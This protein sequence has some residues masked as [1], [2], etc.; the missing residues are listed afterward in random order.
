MAAR[1]IFIP[2]KTLSYLSIV[3][4]GLILGL[5][6]FGQGL[7]VG[8]GADPHQL[9]GCHKAAVAS[10][11]DNSACLASIQAAGQEEGIDE[12]VER[13]ARCLAQG[14]AGEAVP[15]ALTAWLRENHPIYT[16]K[17]PIEADQLRGYLMYLLASGPPNEELFGYVKN[18]LLFAGHAFNVA[19]AAHT[20]RRFPDKGKELMPLLLPFLQGA[21]QEEWVDIT[22]YELNYPLGHPT[23]ARYE[24]IK[25][26][27]HFGPEAYPA[28][29]CLR[30]TLAEEGQRHEALRDAVLIA[31]CQQA[32]DGILSATPLCCRKEAPDEGPSAV[33]NAQFIPVKSRAKINAAGVEWVDQDG[34]PVKYSD[35]TGKPFVLTFF[36]TRCTNMLKCA[37]TVDRLGKLQQL[38]VSGGI[39]KKVGIYAMTYDPDFDRPSILRSYG[40]AYGLSFADKV[41][42]LA[43]QGNSEKGLSEQ[44]GL[45]VG[46]G[47]G[48]V[49]QHGI[50]L[51]VMDKKGRIAFV[52]DN[53]LWSAAAVYGHLRQLMKE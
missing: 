17:S 9:M 27:P 46:Y 28:V 15:L 36:Y 48:S 51:L 19:A 53:E 3:L 16:G 22:T 47:H 7:T 45:R 38:A 34:R 13:A 37:A 32:I 29:K 26:L 49:N 30:A 5:P 50:Q 12:L 1:P 20:A 40:E 41:K 14:S 4:L 23:K 24:V 35:L 25:T 42:F 39:G 44:L 11:P 10:H 18:E 8:Q 33:G 43:A 21:Y 2:M 6:G 31:L 52:Y